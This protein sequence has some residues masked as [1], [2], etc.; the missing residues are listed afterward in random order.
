MRIVELVDF[1]SM[2]LYIGGSIRVVF[3]DEETES[4][5]VAVDRCLKF[6]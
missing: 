2:L 6:C 3:G 1:D 4:V 5:F